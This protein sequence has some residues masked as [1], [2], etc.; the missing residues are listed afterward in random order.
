[1][2]RDPFGVFGDF[3]QILD[4]PGYISRDVVLVLRMKVPFSYSY[5]G[6]FFKLVEIRNGGM[7][8]RVVLGKSIFN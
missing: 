8:R 2:E 1:M 5:E 6:C 3:N 4:F 7:C